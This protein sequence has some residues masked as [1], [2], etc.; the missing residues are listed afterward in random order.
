LRGAV[1]VPL[2]PHEATVNTNIIA[3]RVL[4]ICLSPFYFFEY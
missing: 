4:L 3:R 1:D 2:L